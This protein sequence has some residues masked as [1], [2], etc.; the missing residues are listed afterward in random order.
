MMRSIFL[1]GILVVLAAIAFKKP[2][3]TV[4]EFAREVSA[5]AQGALVA[6][7][8]QTEIKLPVQNPSVGISQAKP[9]KIDDWEII[10]KR[11][12]TAIKKADKK[13]ISPVTLLEPTE[14]ATKPQSVTPSTVRKPPTKI[15]SPSTISPPEM[16]KV[17]VA[18]VN[19]RPLKQGTVYSHKSSTLDSR[20]V[21]SN[22]TEVRLNLE[23]AARLLSEVK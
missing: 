16:P 17:P 1:F 20:S 18:A 19:V 5:T 14:T 7:T 15:V 6:S 13:A 21:K 22:L 12:K 9:K 3:Q 11:I 8:P 10:S 4:L 23:N 2:D